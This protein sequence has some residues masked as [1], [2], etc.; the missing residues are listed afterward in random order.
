MTLFGSSKPRGPVKG[1]P[2]PGRLPLKTRD[3]GL[4]ETPAVWMRSKARDDAARL[5]IPENL[6]CVHGKLYD[7]SK[8]MNRHPGGRYWL[9]VTRGSDI[10]EAVE[11]HHLNEPAVD[12]VLSKTFVRDAPKAAEAA[13]AP[14]FTYKKDGF[15]KTLKRRATEVLGKEMAGHG[16]TGRMKAVCA[17]L[18]GGWL[19]FF[20]GMCLCPGTATPIACALIAATFLH[21]L[22]G[23]GHN[24]FHQRDNMWM[25]TFDLSAFS[26]A[27]WRISHAMSHHFYSNLEMDSEVSSLEPF[28]YFLTNKPR[29]S[30]LVYLTYPILLSLAGPLDFVRHFVAVALRLDRLR[31]EDMLVPLQAAVIVWAQGWR[32]GLA[33]LLLMHMAASLLLASISFAVHRSEH[34]WTEGDAEPK[35]DYGEHIAASTNDHSVKCGLLRSFYCFAGLNY[36]V[37]HHLFP[38]VDHSRLKLLDGVFRQ[39]MKEFN[40][41]YR[42]FDFGTLFRGAMRRHDMLLVPQ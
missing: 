6:W 7:L 14:R 1:A 13:L 21:G 9:E 18:L 34:A 28:L 27:A 4:L 35:L 40:V 11:T 2:L 16:P 20:A 25:Y 39:T 36:H 42:T 10:T 8:F 5:G 33:L 3:T 26:S 15:Y 24:F 23:V 19:L 17:T 30:F 29:N 22:M 41:P 31:P 37:L 32:W 38:T 12:A